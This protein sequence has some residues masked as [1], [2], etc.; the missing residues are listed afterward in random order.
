MRRLEFAP[1]TSWAPGTP[2]RVVGLVGTWHVVGQAWFVD[3][4]GRTVEHDHVIV[5]DT[6]GR[7]EW[8]EPDRLTYAA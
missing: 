1:V 4:D 7:E 2:V 5:T 8:V 6:S 3:D